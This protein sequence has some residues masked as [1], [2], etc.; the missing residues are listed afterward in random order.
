[1]CCKKHKDVE[2]A[3]ECA[4][5]PDDPRASP[6]SFSESCEHWALYSHQFQETAKYLK[7]SSVEVFIIFAPPKWDT[8]FT[9][10][11]ITF[12]SLSV[13]FSSNNLFLYPNALVYRSELD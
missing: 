11:V 12:I 8:S 1:M 9:L 4:W 7:A 13:L 5:I 2:T 6:V 3:L 10:N